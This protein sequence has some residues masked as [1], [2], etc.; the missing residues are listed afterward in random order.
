MSGFNEFSDKLYHLELDELVPLIV[1]LD[2][3]S[4]DDLVLICLGELA[5]R[6]AKGA[7]EEVSVKAKSV[8]AKSVKVE[9]TK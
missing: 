1:I 4:K 2:K 8:K 3:W 9:E 5:D 6:Q 7:S